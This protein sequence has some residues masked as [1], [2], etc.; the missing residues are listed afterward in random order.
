MTKQVTVEELEQ[1]LRE[2]LD[3]VR[4]GESLQIVDGLTPIATIAPAAKRR[5]HVIPHDPALRLQDF[6]PGSPLPG[7]GSVEWLIAERDRERSGKKP[8]P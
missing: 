2:R 7:T 1:Q 8:R 6:E 3:D 4:N 5:A